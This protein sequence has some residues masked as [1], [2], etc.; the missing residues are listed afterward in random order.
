[1]KPLN[2]DIIQTTDE[3]LMDRWQ[4]Q[5][6]QKA[7]A[8][9]YKRHFNAIKKY[10]FWLSNDLE[11]SKDITQD[12]FIKLYEKPGLFT[13]SKPFKPW[14]F[15]VAKNQWKNEI[16]H[17]VTQSKHYE[18]LAQFIKDDPV[19]SE[20]NLDRLQGLN[21]AI[22]TLSD[23]H[24]EVFIL[25]Y[26]NNFSIQEISEICN[27]TEGTVKSRLFYALQNIRNHVQKTSIIHYEKS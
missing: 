8:S 16:R 11:K 26:I 17:K 4:S 15:T 10:L 2:Q 6:D 5:S 7:F 3:V 18:I 24:K 12:I 23:V 25:K 20:N 27:C 19:V 13:T 22:S 14:V 1:M 21:K 9:L